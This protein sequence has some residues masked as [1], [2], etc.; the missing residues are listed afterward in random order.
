MFACTRYT[1]L[2][3]PV[4]LSILGL[5]LLLDCPL[6]FLSG[7]GRPPSEFMS[8]PLPLDDYGSLRLKLVN[9][10]VVDGFHGCPII[11]DTLVKLGSQLS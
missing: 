6:R 11:Y 9:Q 5:L 7:L 3:L 10:P 8:P 1:F 4:S 2:A